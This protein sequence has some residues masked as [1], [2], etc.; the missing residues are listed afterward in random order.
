MIILCFSHNCKGAVIDSY[1]KYGIG[2][3]PIAFEDLD[4]FGHEKTL[5]QCSKTVYPN[6]TCSDNNIVGLLCLDSKFACELCM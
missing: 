1:G 5:L 6:F 2:D 3:N 4:C